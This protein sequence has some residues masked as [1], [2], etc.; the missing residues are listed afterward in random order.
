[1]IARDFVVDTRT[2]LFEVDSLE[3]CMYCDLLLSLL[4]KES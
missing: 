2:V 1:M 4:E 3:F